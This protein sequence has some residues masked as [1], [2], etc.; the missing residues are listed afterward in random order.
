MTK[1]QVNFDGQIRQLVSKV[2]ASGNKGGKLVIEFNLYDDELIGRLAPFIKTDAE[3]K[4]TI[5]E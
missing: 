5:S 4:I 1:N 3:V 2:D